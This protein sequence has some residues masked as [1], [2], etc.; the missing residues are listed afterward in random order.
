MIKREL[1]FY[2]LISFSITCI[3]QNELDSQGRRHGEWKLNFEGSSNPKMIGTYEHGKQVGKFKYYKKGFYDHPS[4][5]LN[6]PE[7]SDSVHAIY[8]TQKGKPISEGK[9]VDRK[10]EGEWLYY[11]QD[12]DSIMLIENYRNDSLNG[13]Q[14]TFYPNGQLAEKTEYLEGKQHGESF[15]YN[16]EG[17]VT[18]YYNYRN[19]QLHGQ[20][21][22]YNAEGEK[23]QE[24]QYVEG[25]KSGTWKYYS[26]GKLEKEE[27]F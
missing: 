21:I 24:G 3:A 4:A 16:E 18:K 7:E 11:H 27:N 19:G 14:K 9:L 20:A 17:K 5:I 26:D 15:I 23:L 8:Y 22:I 2:L 13:L 6:F 12:S 1:I 25:K 10:R